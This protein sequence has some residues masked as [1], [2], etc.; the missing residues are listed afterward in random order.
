[1]VHDP[2][3][4]TREGYDP[5]FLGIDVP[6]PEPVDPALCAL[7][8]DG[9]Y[10]LPYHHFSLVMHKGRR[11]TM[12]TASNLDASP[13]AKEPEPGKSY[14]RK[15]LG[16]LGKN[17]VELWFT[18]P[19]IEPE[20]QLPDRFFS[21]DKGAFDRGHVVRRE[22]VAWGHSYQEVQ[23]ANG[24]TFHTSNCTPQV[25][26][27]NQPKDNENWGDLEKYV[28]SQIGSDR[29][30]IFAGPVLAD[31]DSIF[32]GVDNEGPVRVQI[33]QQYWKVI[34][35]EESGE[36][37]AFAFLLRQD[38]SGVPLE[39][40]VTAAWREHM[41]AVSDLED[42]LGIVRFPEVVQQADQAHADL[43]EA[44]RSL[45]SIELV[46]GPPTGGEQIMRPTPNSGDDDYAEPPMTEA[47]PEVGL[48]A[49]I[50]WRVA[51]SLLKLRRQVDAK[52]PRRSKASDGTIGDAAHAS[53]ASD[54]NP[55]V[56]D[57]AM[58]VVTAMDI[59]HDPANGCDANVLAEAILASQ[60]VRVKYVIWNRRIASSYEVNGVAPWIW[61]PYGGT[62]PHTKHMHLSVLP[63]K[64]A[65]DSEA[66][67]AI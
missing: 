37:R 21:K 64:A 45:A 1:P 50:P 24:D 11:L 47:L 65:F 27:F 32:V 3:Y 67:W 2:E 28:S 17:D 7:L 48:E 26:G 58:G 22:D 15:A 29:L 18:D 31:D 23:Y 36:L 39:F 13:E 35:A 33:P 20:D 34:L 51:K 46:E 63:E 12:F 4:S 57:G 5:Q 9:S 43:G 30:S 66:A 16:G 55:W 53:R 56:R 59:T 40:A 41:I 61:R 60:D 54:H 42:L 44:V 25:A 49:L 6:M 38:L 14:T 52:A 19:R 62:N 8:E 10:V